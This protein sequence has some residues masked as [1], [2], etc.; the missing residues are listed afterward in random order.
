[1]TTLHFF[2]FVGTLIIGLVLTN[3]LLTFLKSQNALD[4]PNHRSSHSA[5]TIRG[6]GLAFILTFLLSSG[7]GYLFSIIQLDSILITLMLTAI[8]I[9]L[10]GATDD[11]FKI[12]KKLRLLIELSCIAV[13][14]YVCQGAIHLPWLAVGLIAFLWLWFINLFNF[15]DGADGLA[16]QQAIFIFIALAIIS[17]MLLPLTIILL[18]ACLCFYKINLPPARAFM[19]DV[20]SLFLGYLLFGLMLYAALYQ[21][22][23][24]LQLFAISSFFVIDATY[25][26]LKRLLQGKNI[27]EAHREHWYQRFLLL[28]HTH[29]ELLL[30]SAIYNLLALGMVCSSQS[31]F[32]RLSVLFCVYSMF[33]IYVTIHEKKELSSS[34]L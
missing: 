1:M 17:P 7:I 22:A 13:V 30:V 21:Q 29:I 28:G 14:L 32:F 31:A 12:S 8:P 16:T 24:I 2:W 18:A 25:T 15:M 27:L 11:L 3:P 6:G 10:V 4:I 33:I 20:G 34:S 23:N 19:G 5:V 9:A 26:L